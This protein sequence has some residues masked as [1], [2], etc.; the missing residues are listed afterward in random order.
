MEDFFFFLSTI[1]LLNIAGIWQTCLGLGLT[2]SKFGS[3]WFTVRK[4][5]SPDQFL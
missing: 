1:C 5:S 2:L 4:V 3:I